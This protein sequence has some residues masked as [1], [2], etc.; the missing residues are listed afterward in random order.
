[1]HPGTKDSLHADGGDKPDLGAS[2]PEN[3]GHIAGTAAQP[4]LLRSGMQV[5]LTF[6][7]MLHADNDIDTGRAEYKNMF[8]H[9]ETSFPYI[10]QQWQDLPGAD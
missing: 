6:R 9:T 5:F 4:E 7:Q 2:V 8:T 3:I 1:M 10:R